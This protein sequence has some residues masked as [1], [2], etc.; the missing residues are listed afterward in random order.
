MPLI[1]FFGSSLKTANIVLISAALALSGCVT[2]PT[3]QELAATQDECSQFRTPFTAISEERKQRVARFAQIGAGAGAIVGQQIAR[4][5]N[6][7]ELAGALIGLIAGATLG[8]TAG[9]LDDLQR[10]SSTTEGLQ[11]AVNGD[12]SRDLRETDRLVSA[13]TSLNEC[14]LR[15][16]ADVQASVR[17]GGDR[18]AAAATVRQIRQ[19]VAVDNRVIEAVVG[20][21]TQTRNLYI[22]ALNQTGADTD[23]FVASIQQY[24]PQV[25]S[26]Q[27]TSLRIDRARRPQTNSP[28]ANLGY[29]E[30]ELSAGAAVHVQTIDAALDDLNALL[31]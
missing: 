3:A 4:R 27:Q 20:D 5:N 31:I 23:G 15:Q 14:R 11:R 25:I 2:A 28:V 9:Y 6:D 22:G 12:A 19:K 24:Q 29:A 21:L 13:M 26:P 8:A 16:I 17:A 30:R 10:R 1:P 7:D 18:E